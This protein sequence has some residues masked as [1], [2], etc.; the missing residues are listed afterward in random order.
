MDPSCSALG[1][2]VDLEPLSRQ[3]GRYASGVLCWPKVGGAI[4]AAA[5]QG[6]NRE[7]S[8]QVRPHALPPPLGIEYRGV[9]LRC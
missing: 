5:A 4:Q 1:Q 6:H 7:L 3:W 8:Q 9:G 2:P